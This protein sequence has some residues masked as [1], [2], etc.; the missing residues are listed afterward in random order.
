MKKVYYKNGRRYA[1]CIGCGE[2]WNIAK[3]QRV[4]R[5]GYICPHCRAKI[6]KKVKEDEG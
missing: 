4:F 6:K 2:E 5:D 1:E 3:G